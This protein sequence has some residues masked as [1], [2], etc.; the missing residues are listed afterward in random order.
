[1]TT[2]KIEEYEYQSA[3]TP[4]LD[5]EACEAFRLLIRNQE[6]MDLDGSDEFQDTDRAIT[7]PAPRALMI[8]FAEKSKEVLQE[9]NIADDVLAE[10]VI[11]VLDPLIH[12]NASA[13][14]IYKTLLD[15]MEKTTNIKVKEKMRDISVICLEAVIKDIIKQL[16]ERYQDE[17]NLLEIEG[18]LRSCW[19]KVISLRMRVTL[20][21]LV[22]DCINEAEKEEQKQNISNAFILSMISL[23]TNPD[24]DIDFEVSDDDI[25]TALS[26]QGKNFAPLER[27]RTPEAFRFS[28]PRSG[29]Q[30]YEFLIRC[31]EEPR[32]VVQQAL[33]LLKKTQNLQI[34]PHDFESLDKEAFEQLCK[35]YYIALRKLANK[36]KS[37]ELQG[38]ILT[39]WHKII[40][41][42]LMILGE[43]RF[44]K[45]FL[46]PFAKS[47]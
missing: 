31:N 43:L 37:K 11:K 39:M 7:R 47:C 14:D 36:A 23:M 44:S 15:E 40:G 19:N 4:I 9:H 35:N 24:G 34:I 45:T 2:E 16:M 30:I 3:P 33:D 41:P 32:D 22:K 12:M 8:Y 6:K 10:Q 27:F 17:S 5:E 42:Q 13:Q 21:T 28:Y 46:L 29:G 18:H 38:A 1:M 20:V 25:L 26:S